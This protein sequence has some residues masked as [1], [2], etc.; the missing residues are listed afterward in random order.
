MLS[1]I[2]AHWTPDAHPSVGYK[3][4]PKLYRG[5]V[6]ESL[7]DLHEPA[8]WTGFRIATPAPS[9]SSPGPGPGPVHMTVRLLR[10]DGSPAFP[11][12]E[13]IPTQVGCW[14]PFPWAI[15]AKMAT[16]MGLYLDITGLPDSQPYSVRIAFQEMK[17]LSVQDRY[18]F[19]EN[20][21]V[22]HMWDGRRKVCNGRN[23]RMEPGMDCRIRLGEPMWRTFHILVPPMSRLISEPRWD[24]DKPFCIHAWDEP[25]PQ[26]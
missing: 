7:G 13:E 5:P 6:Q 25:V 14:T 10:Q 22:H 12:Y 4:Y 21:E 19:V 17:Q 23:I 11:F 15:P 8:W 18:L 3:Q 2:Y 1:D 9:I 20:G 16:I 24:D 26:Y